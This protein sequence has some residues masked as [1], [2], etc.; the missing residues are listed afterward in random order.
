VIIL[1]DYTQLREGDEAR[2]TGKLLQVPVGKDLLGRVVN[3]LGEPMDGKGP[4]K[5]NI[6]Y[7]VEKTAPGIVRRQSVNQ[8]RADRHHAH[9]RDDSDWP[10]PARVD[11]WR[12]FDR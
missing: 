7:P 5:S 9:R 8:P 2:T 1:G 11:H 6:A 10:R 3:T 4:I 12:P